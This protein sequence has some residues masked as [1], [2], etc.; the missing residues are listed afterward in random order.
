MSGRKN[1]KTKK[2]T[3]KKRGIKNR[4]T[5]KTRDENL[6]T[7]KCPTEISRTKIGPDAKC[8]YL[9][10]FYGLHPPPSPRKVF[11]R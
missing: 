11:R 1:V 2:Y 5:K 7:K 3:T 4:A 10:Y 9:G 8:V 6:R